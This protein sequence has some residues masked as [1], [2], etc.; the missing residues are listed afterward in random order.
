[1]D[2][3]TLLTNRRSIRDFRDRNVPLSVVKEIIQ[4]TCLAPTASNRQPCRFVIIQE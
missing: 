1:M 2:F 3:E 4:D